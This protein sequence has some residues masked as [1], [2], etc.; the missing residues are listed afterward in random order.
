MQDLDSGLPIFLVPDSGGHKKA[1]LD[2]EIYELFSSSEAV[3]CIKLS[4]S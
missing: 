4:I 2:L 1:W 3:H